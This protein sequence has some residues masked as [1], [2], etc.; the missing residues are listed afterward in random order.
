MARDVIRQDGGSRHTE[1]V[2]RL[3]DDGEQVDRNWQVWD[4]QAA[5]VNPKISRQ[6]DRRGV[7]GA[8]R[9]FDAGNAEFLKCIGQ[10]H[11]K[12]IEE[13]ERREVEGQRHDDLH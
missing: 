8:D 3:L 13:V 7:G 9:L 5:Q 6:F 10:S 1:G 12:W 2:D 4:G 11:T